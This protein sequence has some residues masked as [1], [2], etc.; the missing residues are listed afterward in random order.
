M[1]MITQATCRIIQPKH[2]LKRIVMKTV[3]AYLHNWTVNKLHLQF[4]KQC[5]KHWCKCLIIECISYVN[6]LILLCFSENS[7]FNIL[8]FSPRDFGDIS[9]GIWLAND[10]FV[11]CNP[12]NCLLK[13]CYKGSCLQKLKGLKVNIP[14]QLVIPH[15]FR[16]LPLEIDYKEFALLHERT[17][18]VPMHNTKNNRI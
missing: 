4:F 1:L 3:F 11:L 10:V 15:Y 2:I 6:T 5:S 12:P 13:I 8:D 14:R 18:L 9:T 7:L 17:K 16:F